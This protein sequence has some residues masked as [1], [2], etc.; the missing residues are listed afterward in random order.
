VQRGSTLKKTEEQVV[1]GV[2][3]GNKRIGIERYQV[4]GKHMVR[5]H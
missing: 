1:M 2:R 4:V 3:S 5:P